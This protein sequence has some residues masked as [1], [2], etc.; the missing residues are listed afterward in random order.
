MLNIQPDEAVMAF[1]APHACNIVVK[2]VISKPLF[3]ALRLT[4][5]FSNIACRR[6]FSV[7]GFLG[8]A[9]VLVLITPFQDVHPYA[10]TACFSA[11]MALVGFHPSGFKA[12]YMDVTQVNV[13]SHCEDESPC[14]VRTNKQTNKPE[15][16]VFYAILL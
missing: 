1:M 6:I 13:A 14:T 5:G 12:N 3:S 15:G 8:A 4:C 10:V 11:A 7:V 16:G 2:L 9:L